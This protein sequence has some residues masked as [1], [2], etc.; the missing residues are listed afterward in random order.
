MPDK[1]MAGFVGLGLMGKPMARNLLKAGYKVTVHNRSQGAVEELTK[2]GA[3]PAT[4][5]AE[6]AR[7]SQIIFTS[8]PGP[9]EVESV[10]LGPGGIVGELQPGSIIVEMSTLDPGTHQKVAAAAAERQADYLDAPVSG[11]PSG[12]ES[13]TLSIMV[14][15]DAAVLERARPVLEVLG[16]NIY[17]MGPLGSGAIVKLVNNL[18]LAINAAGVAEGLVLGVKAGLDPDQL[19]EVIGNSSGTSRMFVYGAPS[20]LNRDF[21]PGFMVDS[22]HKD[23]HLAVALGRENGVRLLAGSLASQ[24]LEEARAAGHGRKSIFAQILALEANARIE[25]KGKDG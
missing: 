17:H 5:P 25:V 13:G 22:L 18:L 15:G 9:A 2:E 20:I 1:P 7:A 3:T 11:G 16:Q 4:S 6:V 23:V 14:G 19:V 24:I 10:Y 12:A 8:L 21:A